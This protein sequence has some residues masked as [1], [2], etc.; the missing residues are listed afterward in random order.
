MAKRL[1][2]L[3]PLALI[4]CA[5]PP[6]GPRVMA[7]P[8]TTTNYQTFQ[9][10]DALCRQ[11]ARQQS[12]GDTPAETATST[13][14]TGGLV[15]ASLGA[16]TGAAISGGAG[17]STAAGA[18]VGLLGGTLMGQANAAP[19]AGAVQAAYDQAYSQCMYGHGHQI[20]LSANPLVP[21]SA[22][23]KPVDPDLS[24]PLPPRFEAED[25]P[26]ALPPRSK[27]GNSF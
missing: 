3:G 25:T 26:L 6:A 13:T 7:L 24:L 19:S 22:A 4:A 17:S 1:A 18:G 8:G 10:D 12:G 20:P 21:A 5:S 27:K 9:T 14:A 23:G 16:A 11:S 15:G 2:L